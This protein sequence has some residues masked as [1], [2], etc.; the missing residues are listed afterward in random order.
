MNISVYDVWDVGQLYL[1]ELAVSVH[2][3]GVEV[4]D[5]FCNT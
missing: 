1:R 2:G 3:V 4:I 5:Y